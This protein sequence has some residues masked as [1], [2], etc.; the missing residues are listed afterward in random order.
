MRYN[1]RPSIP[2]SNTPCLKSPRSTIEIA[3]GAL[4][5]EC[6]LSVEWR[7]HACRH[8][9]WNLEEWHTSAAIQHHDSFEALE[10]SAARGCCLC[11]SFRATVYYNLGTMGLNTPPTGPCFLWL[12]TKS[13][14]GLPGTGDNFDA[15]NWPV[16]C[17]FYVG[18]VLF[19]LPISVHRMIDNEEFMVG[20]IIVT[21]DTLGD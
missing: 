16:V 17:R 21:H 14:I 20:V 4:A 15:G 10:T 7:C 8:I 13:S 19:L 11:R 3:Q 2:E 1:S 18:N 5:M 6:Q 12:P 9:P